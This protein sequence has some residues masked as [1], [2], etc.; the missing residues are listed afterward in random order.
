MMINK[1]YIVCDN[2]KE[3]IDLRKFFLTNGGFTNDKTLKFFLDENSEKYFVNPKII[4]L[5]IENNSYSYSSI[6]LNFLNSK[7]NFEEKLKELNK[8]ENVAF[9]SFKTYEKTNFTKDLN[10]FDKEKIKKEQQ[11]YINDYIKWQLESGTVNV[12]DYL[13]AKNGD[14]LTFKNEKI[15]LIQFILLTDNVDMLK[16][17][18]GNEYISKQFKNDPFNVFYDKDLQPKCYEFIENEKEIVQT[19][20]SF[21]EIN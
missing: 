2:P 12:N 3:S 7:F 20:N 6:N 19:I 13:K 10:L 5:T 14:Y 18:L 4:E 11:N 16:Y 1:I 15:N 17:C 9:V 8:N 21:G